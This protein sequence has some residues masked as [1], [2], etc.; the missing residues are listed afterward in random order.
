MRCDLRS[1]C[2][3][4][5]GPRSA[6]G[7]AALA[8]DRISVADTGKT[9]PGCCNSDSLASMAMA[10]DSR[11]SPRAIWPAATKIVRQTNTARIDWLRETATARPVIDQMR[12]TMRASLSFEKRMD[13][14]AS[15][16]FGIA[17][18]R[19]EGK[20]K[21]GRGKAEGKCTALRPPPSAFPLP[22]NCHKSRPFLR[23]RR[24][25]CL[26]LGPGG[27]DNSGW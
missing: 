12:Q 8:S 1:D 17:S 25:E 19:L 18:Q 4:G 22:S 23:I 26:T 2:R 6:F 15:G 7:P 5:L 11:T 20:G 27:R 13:Q 10:V 9:I 24:A 21:G 3:I 14:Q 16:V